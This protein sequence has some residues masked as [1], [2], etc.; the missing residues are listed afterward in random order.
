[1]ANIGE[2]D[3]RPDVWSLFGPKMT[4]EIGSLTPIFNTPLKVAK[5]DI[6][7]KTDAKP[8]EKYWE[9]DQNT[10]IFNLF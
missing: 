6:Y 2:H 8:V 10:R 7:A 5:I 3:W 9:N 4:Q 1:M